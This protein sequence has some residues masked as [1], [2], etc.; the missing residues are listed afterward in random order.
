MANW[1][2][3]IKTR[4]GDFVFTSLGPISGDLGARLKREVDN[5][6]QGQATIIGFFDADHSDLLAKAL[7]SR[8]ASK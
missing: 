6:A 1:Q 5:T 8:H 7:E 4:S 2:K 3:V